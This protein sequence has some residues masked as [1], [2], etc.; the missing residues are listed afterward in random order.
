VID[1]SHTL[2]QA[3]AVLLFTA[4]VVASV[5]VVVGGAFTF[6]GRARANPWLALGVAS[7]LSGLTA[8]WLLQLISV[9][10]DCT[11][12]VPFPY[13]WTYACSRA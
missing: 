3:L 7:L 10:N 6:A 2:R 1:N 8:Y 13:T 5:A 9:I 4:V 12:A 11:V